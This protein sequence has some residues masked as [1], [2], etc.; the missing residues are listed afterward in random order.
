MG[1]MDIFDGGASRR[2]RH[3]KR[4]QRI[5]EENIEKNYEFEWGDPDSEE[6]GGQQLRK[7]DFAVEGLEILKRNTENNLAYQEANL[8]QRYNHGMSIRAYEHQQE[9][10]AYAQSVD[11]ALNQTSFDQLAERVANLDQDRF[12]HEKTLELAY[13]ET[14]TMLAYGRAAAG[15]GLKQRKAKSGAAIEAQTARISA[16]KAVGSAVSRGVSGRSA[17]KDVQGIMAEAGARQRAIIDQLLFDT[18]ATDLDF[19][20]LNRQFII[21]QVGFDMT[22]EG[23]AM[24]DM[25]ARNKIKA[26]ALQAAIEAEAS[27]ALKPEITPALPKPFALPR[28]EFQDI[29]KPEKPPMTIV[30]PAAK[31]SV[32]LGVFNQVKSVASLATGMGWTPFPNAPIGGSGGGN[33]NPPITMPDDP[34]LVG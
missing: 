20:N 4:V 2:N 14:E 32:A 5:Q 18:E 16:L 13:D 33:V 9:Q 27:I 10:R 21:D 6:L 17:G 26:Q 30:P 15:L 7:Y 1:L 3:A 28:A 25:S 31:E 34:R 22:R 23:I 29:F 8:V 11:R 12:T 19:M 24:S